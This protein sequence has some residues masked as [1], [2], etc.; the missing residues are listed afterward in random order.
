MMCIKSTRVSHYSLV[1]KDHLDAFALGFCQMQRSQ[2]H[3]QNLLEN[4]YL[5]RLGTDGGQTLVVLKSIQNI[6]HGRQCILGGRCARIQNLNPTFL[7][8]HHL[9]ALHSLVCLG[10][11]SKLGHVSFVNHQPWT[12]G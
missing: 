1:L 12:K 11:T 8:S 7:R 5:G 6:Q 2:L 10:K 3:L 4:S 9:S